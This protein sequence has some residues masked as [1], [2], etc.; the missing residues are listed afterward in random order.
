MS[1]SQE[2]TRGREKAH[3][4]GGGWPE[5]LLEYDDGVEKKTSWERGKAW[6]NTA[7]LVFKEGKEQT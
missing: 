6:H 4:K 2:T 3:G 7:G 1:H 5:A